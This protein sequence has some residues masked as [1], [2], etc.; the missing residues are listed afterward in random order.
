MG[1]R[2]CKYR[3]CK[4]FPPFKKKNIIFDLEGINTVTLGVH[5]CVR[6]SRAE[7]PALSLVPTI[8]TPAFVFT[9]D[10]LTVAK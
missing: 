1:K 9:I 2:A 8:R 5:T 7:P 10:L 4:K 3:G 6:R